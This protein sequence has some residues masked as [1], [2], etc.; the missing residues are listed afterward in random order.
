MVQKTYISYT[1]D[2]QNLDFF[3]Y[4]LYTST[5]YLIHHYFIHIHCI[6]YTPPLYPLQLYILQPF[7]F[8]T[9][10]SNLYTSPLALYIST[11]F[12]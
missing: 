6:A 2:V 9:P 8:Y 12:I 11:L 5:L 10:P 3:L 4:I 1:I 7:Q